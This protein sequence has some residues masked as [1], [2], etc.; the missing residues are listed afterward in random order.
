[1]LELLIVRWIPP[2]TE[3]GAAADGLGSVFAAASP[4]ESKLLLDL[5]RIMPY[6]C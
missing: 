2:E 3:Y 1:M 4:A 6:Y 5:R